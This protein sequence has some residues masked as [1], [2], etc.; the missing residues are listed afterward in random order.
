[1][2]QNL[3]NNYLYSANTGI[4]FT[5][6]GFNGA[7]LQAKS[8]TIGGSVYPIDQSML[9]SNN[10]NIH[11]D[12][13]PRNGSVSDSRGATSEV[14][15]INSVA[16]LTNKHQSLTQ[17]R[18][19]QDSNGHLKFRDHFQTRDRDNVQTQNQS[20]DVNSLGGDPVNIS[21]LL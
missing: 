14:N 20:Y 3:H 1:M 8:G 17:L 21:N 4:L 18:F 19:N 15:Q 7:L 13:M 5:Q 2:M 6:R 16:A 12:L 11:K 10:G 9:L